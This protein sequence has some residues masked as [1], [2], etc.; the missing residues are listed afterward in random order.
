MNKKFLTVNTLT[1]FNNTSFN[2]DESGQSK[3]C[4]VG[5]VI[6]GRISS[7]CLKYHWRR[8]DTMSNLDLNSGIKH[9]RTRKAFS[10]LLF[11]KIKSEGVFDEKTILTYT[12]E[13]LASFKN[14]KR[15]P[16]K[17]EDSKEESDKKEKKSTA[18]EQKASKKELE[19]QQVLCFAQTELDFLEET[20]RD[21]LSSNDINKVKKGLD[22]K[23]LKYPLT[24]SVALS[25]KFSTEANLPTVESSLNV[26]HSFSV[27]QHSSDHDFFIASD[28]LG[29]DT[30]A[31]H[32]GATDITSNTFYGFLVIDLNK[33]SLNRFSTSFDNLEVE[34]KE[35]LLNEISVFVETVCKTAPSGKSSATAPQQ[36]AHFLLLELTNNPTGLS[37]AFRKAIPNNESLIPTAYDRI[38]SFLS[39][40]DND[41]GVESI[42][43]YFGQDISESQKLSFENNL[44]SKRISIPTLKEWLQNNL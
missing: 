14:P 13:L 17:D 31:A 18:K 5:G 29:V 15:D 34:N 1:S 26:A 43:G 9:T 20:L 16:S 3:T 19:S 41:Y 33:Y 36:K 24:P 39:D 42:R 22:L 32:L 2:H 37:N 11:E 6:R 7:Q 4:M 38:I 35:K 40:M 27:H 28:D 25:G 10:D 44:S 23:K 30:G 12:N 21:A 8:S